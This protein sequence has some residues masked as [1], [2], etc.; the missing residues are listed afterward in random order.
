MGTGEMY[1]RVGCLLWSAGYVNTL[2][3]LLRIATDAQGN[4]NKRAQLIQADQITE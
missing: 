1:A 4:L 3:L 2:L